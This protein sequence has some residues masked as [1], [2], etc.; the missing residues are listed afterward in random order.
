[1]FI[2]NICVVKNL[3]KTVPIK[4]TDMNFN[5][6]SN[7]NICISTKC[8]IF[9]IFLI[10]SPRSNFMNDF[11]FHNEIDT[12][13]TIKKLICAYKISNKKSGSKKL[14]KIFRSISFVFCGSGK[15]CPTK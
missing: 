9:D 10:F 4:T 14:I 2:R 5:F 11:R 12:K 6:V 1:M 13:Q 8:A 7:L 3:K 15:G